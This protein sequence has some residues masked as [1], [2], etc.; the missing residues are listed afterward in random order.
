MKGIV[1]TEFLDLVED[2]FGLE[3]VDKIISQSKLESKGYYTAVG[4]YSFSE[5]LQLLQNLSLNTK[6]SIDNLLLVFAEHFFSVLVRDYPS[7]IASYKDPIEMISSVESHIHVEV[8]KI[9]PNAELPTFTVV[10]KCNDYL[11][12]IYKSGRAMHY[13][14]L[15]LMKKT[16][17]HF[18]TTAKIDFQKIKDDGTEVKF[19]IQKIT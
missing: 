3:M 4:T 2:K 6:I 17:E 5:M 1:F 15:G 10:E 8:K 11:S 12:M 16:F 18:N 19:I 14:G 9:Y 13:F 7:V